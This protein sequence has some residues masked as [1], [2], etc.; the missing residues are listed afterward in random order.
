MNFNANVLTLTFAVLLSIGAPQFAAGQK[1][2]TSYI[3]TSPASSGVI[4]IAKEARFF[5]KHGIDATVIFISGSIRR[6]W[7]TRID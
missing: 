2:M 1:I 6:R 5:E 3:S 7:W 4:W